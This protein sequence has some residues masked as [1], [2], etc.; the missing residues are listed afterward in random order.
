[1]KIVKE[2][3]SVILP[4]IEELEEFGDGDDKDSD[5]ATDFTANVKD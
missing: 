5:F 4:R 3:M 2:Q 1:M